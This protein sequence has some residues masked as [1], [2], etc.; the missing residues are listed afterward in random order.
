[1]SDPVWIGN[2]KKRGNLRQKGVKLES[3]GI[4]KRLRSTMIGK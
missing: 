1:M 4:E 2:R 3:D